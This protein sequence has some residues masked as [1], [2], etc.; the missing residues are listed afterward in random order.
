MP[1]SCAIFFK[2]LGA[3][4]REASHCR[5][6]VCAALF[7]TL[8]GS[9]ASGAMSGSAALG[10]ATIAAPQ[11][12]HEPATVGGSKATTLP[13]PPQVTSRAFSVIGKVGCASASF[14][15]C[16]AGALDSGSAWVFP[17]N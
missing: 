5:T 1:S 11:K 2:A 4:H 9:T 16:A 8:N 10:S 14:N 7:G 13:Q 12:E 3:N 15:G 17:Q 6:S